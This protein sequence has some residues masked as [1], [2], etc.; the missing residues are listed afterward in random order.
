M[1]TL[2]RLLCVVAAAVVAVFI[3]MA[4]EVVGTLIIGT[5]K[6]AASAEYAAPD[7]S[8]YF[9]TLMAPDH[10]D[11]RCCGEADAYRVREVGMTP[12]GE[13]IIEVTDTGPDLFTIFPDG[14]RV[15]GNHVGEMPGSRLI[16]RAHIAEG[17]RIIVPRH[18]MRK[19]PIANPTDSAIAFLDQFGYVFCYE[20]IAGI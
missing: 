15:P 3:Y 2:S 7:L 16:S 8:E 11:V 20:P 12:D 6:P 1:L 13:L 10:P 14:R 9:D 18:K 5:I 4:A 17:T 19:V